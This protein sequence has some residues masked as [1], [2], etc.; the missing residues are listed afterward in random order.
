MAQRQGQALFRIL[1]D[2]IQTAE[3]VQREE[4]KFPTGVQGATWA[5]ERQRNCQPFR[6]DS[7][8]EQEP[9]GVA[10]DVKSRVEQAQTVPGYGIGIKK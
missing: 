1:L 5:A 4:L 10:Y 2:K 6:W 7:Q 3:I 8:M 9:R